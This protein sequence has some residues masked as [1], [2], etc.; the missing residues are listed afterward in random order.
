M[1]YALAL[2]TA[3]ALTAS[4]PA[5]AAI[6]PQKGMAK[7]RLGMTVQDVNAARG[8]PDHNVTSPDDLFGHTRTYTYGTVKVLFDGTRRTSEVIL[9]ETLQP[10]ERTVAGVGVGSKRSTVASSVKGV[11]CTV[12]KN[13]VDHCVV[14]EYKAHQTITEFRVGASGL[15]NRVR[16]GIVFPARRKPHA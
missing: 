2:A 10:G 12:E 9:I 8:V 4:A 7:I 1:R 3:L 14:G 5:G 16:I 11:H 6:V 13:G 15:V